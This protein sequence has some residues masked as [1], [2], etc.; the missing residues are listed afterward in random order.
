MSRFLPLFAALRLQEPA[1]RCLIT[2]ALRVFRH[3]ERELVVIDCQYSIG[4]GIDLIVAIKKIIASVPIVCITPD[5]SAETELRA[6]KAGA[7]VVLPMSVRT[8]ELQE[9]VE[10]LLGLKRTAREKRD[11]CYVPPAAIPE[12]QE[13]RPIV[14]YIVSRVIGYMEEHYAERISLDELAELAEMSKFHF[15]RFFL[16]HAGMPPIKYLTMVRMRKAK[17]LLKKRSLTVAAIAELTGYNDVVTFSR[18]FKN[19]T[20]AAPSQLRNA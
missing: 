3:M 4:S 12:P 1:E 15:S 6:A 14:P 7:R 13:V 8:E 5:G 9:A 19:V 16:Q 2:D 17:E 20:G 11:P 10:Q 18:Q